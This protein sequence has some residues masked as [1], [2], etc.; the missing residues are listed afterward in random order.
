MASRACAQ[1]RPVRAGSGSGQC[2]SGTCPCL[3]S[4]TVDW[5][6]ARPAN[7]QYKVNTETAYMGLLFPSIYLFQN[8]ILSKIKIKEFCWTFLNS[9]LIHFNPYQKVW[10]FY[11]WENVHALIQWPTSSWPL[12]FS[13]S[14]C[15]DIWNLFNIISWLEDSFCLQGNSSRHISCRDKTI[16]NFTVYLLD[17]FQHNLWNI[18][19]QKVLMQK[20][21]FT[22]VNKKFKTF[23]DLKVM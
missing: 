8:E 5:L 11:N 6:P 23:G 15:M 17:G 13:C 22:V 16:R 20:K 1:R 21:S 19:I 9:L 10:K 14:C 12:T 18:K 3:Y 2:L 7:V 4:L